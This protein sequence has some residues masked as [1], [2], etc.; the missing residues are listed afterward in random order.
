MIKS[1]K[2]LF[3][4]FGIDYD[5]TDSLE[6]NSLRLSHRVY[7]NTNCGAWAK[8][9]W[10]DGIYTLH[11]GTIVEGSDAEFAAD[12][13]DLPCSEAQIDEAIAWLEGEAE[14]AWNEANK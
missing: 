11:L 4:H 9:T 6:M 1:P 14:A 12:P 2:D 3:E 8:L 10:A 7:K 5:E 13:I